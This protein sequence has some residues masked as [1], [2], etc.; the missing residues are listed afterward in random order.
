VNAVNASWNGTLA[1]NA[2]TSFGF[3][4]TATAIGN[5]PAPTGLSCTA[6]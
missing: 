3:N 5:N 6:G 2:T 4:A 1:P